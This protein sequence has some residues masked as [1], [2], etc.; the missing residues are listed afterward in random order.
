[1]I[2][3]TNSCLTALAMVSRIA[4]LALGLMIASSCRGSESE[5]TTIAVNTLEQSVRVKAM[6][7]AIRFFDAE[8]V[9]GRTS[10]YE[11]DAPLEEPIARACDIAGERVRGASTKARGEATERKSQIPFVYVVSVSSASGHNDTLDLVVEFYRNQEAVRWLRVS[12]KRE[13]T[14][15]VVTRI[16]VEDAIA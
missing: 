5:P 9:R 13:S 11:V 12:L 15:W 14:D 4:A 7:S 2:F 6:S 1:M 10:I 3:T 16:E 8:V